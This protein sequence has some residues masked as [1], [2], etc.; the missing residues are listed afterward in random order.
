[1]CRCSLWLSECLRVARGGAPIC[2]FTDWRQ[3]PTT[4]DALQ[5]GGWVWR[6][7]AV[8]DKTEGCRPSRGRFAAQTEFVVWGSSGPM[9]AREDVGCLPG[10]FR[11]FPK[12]DDKHHIAGKPTPVM[13]QIVGICPPDGVVLD[14]FAGSATTGVAAIRKGRRF[15]GCDIG[16]HWTETSRVRLEAEAAGVSLQAAQ[17][18]QAPLFGERT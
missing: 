3:L 6:G 17:A 11:H 5:A 1:M 8:W 15:L 12:R 14:P 18:G 16:E 7:I 2:L 13:E 9:P 4:T 10:V